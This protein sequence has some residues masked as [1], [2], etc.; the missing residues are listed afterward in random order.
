MNERWIFPF[1]E[2]IFKVNWLLVFWEVNWS[3][4][5]F[6]E[7]S[8]NLRFQTVDMYLAPFHTEHPWRNRQ[9]KRLEVVEKICC[10]KATQKLNAKNCL[11]P[12]QK[13]E[14][15]LQIKRFFLCSNK[16]GPYVSFVLKGMRILHRSSLLASRQKFPGPNFRV[17]QQLHVG[18]ISGIIFWVRKTYQIGRFGDSFCWYLC[19]AVPK[20]SPRFISCLVF[21]WFYFCLSQGHEFQKPISCA[22]STGLRPGFLQQLHQL[23]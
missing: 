9:E 17:H 2:V 1:Q 15:Q 5:F 21:P 4:I 8:V 11:K 14:Q 13:K 12:Q 7:G 18:S 20:F 10:Y 19:L 23:I 22:M 3:P 16:L 6:G